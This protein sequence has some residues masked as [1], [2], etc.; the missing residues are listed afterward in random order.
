L[1]RADC[2]LLERADE[3]AVGPAAQ[4]PIE[5]GLAH[6]ERQA[7]Q[8]LTVDRQY[9]KGAELHLGIVLAGMQ[10][11]EIGYPVDSE[12]RLADASSKIILNGTTAVSIL[13]PY[14]F[15]PTSNYLPQSGTLTPRYSI[16]H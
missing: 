16:Q 10:R 12:D 4:Q 13:T 2:A 5:V 3:D 9:V 14:G 11:V 1:I 8:I 7:A 6:R 15:G